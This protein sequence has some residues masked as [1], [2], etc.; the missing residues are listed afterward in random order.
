MSSEH[1]PAPVE[2]HAKDVSADS[3]SASDNDGESSGDHAPRA[4]WNYY[5]EKPHSNQYVPGAK[6]PAPSGA[7]VNVESFTQN[8]KTLGRVRW[9]LQTFNILLDICSY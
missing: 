1:P 8:L 6:A 7:V 9:K 3:S 4:I 2:V 5:F